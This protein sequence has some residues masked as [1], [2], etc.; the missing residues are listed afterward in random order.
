MSDMQEYVVTAKT[1]DDATS[2]L[3]DMETIGGSLYIPDRQVEVTQR[4]EISRNTHFL[5]TAEEAE[6]LRNDTRVLA[7]ELLPSAQGIVAEPH[8]TQTGNFE[9][10][11]TIDTNDKNW[12]LYRIIAGAPLAN[13]GTNAIAFTQTTQTITTTSSGKN[14]DVVIVDAHINPLHPEF[15]VNSDGTG[16][17]RVNQYNWFQHSAYLALSTTGS[18]SYS[19]ISSNHGTHV[20]GTVAGN[21]QGWARDA[22]IYNMEF[23]YAGGNGPAGDWSLY[24]FDYLRAFHLNKPINPA[25]GKRNPTV[26]NHSWGY[27][28]GSGITVSAVTSVTYRGVTTAV[29]GTDADK[30]VTLEANGVPVPFDSYLYRP[31]YRYPALDAD[32]Q[33]AIAEGIIVVS[34]AGNSYWNCATPDLQD[35]FNTVT[36]TGFGSWGHMRGSSPGAADNVI[37]VGSV[38]TTTQEY[39]SVF[40]NYGKRVD[41]WAPGSNIVS[42]V[43]NTTAAAEFGITLVNDP[44]NASYKLGS[45]SGT[46]MSGPQ[47]AG[48]LACVA[49]QQPRLKQAEALQHL[50]SNSNTT[51]GNSTATHGMPGAQATLTATNSRGVSMNQ[52]WYFH[53]YQPDVGIRQVQAGWLV[54]GPG[55]VNVEIA[56]VNHSNVQSTILI[57]SVNF[58]TGQSQ[59]FQ[60]EGE[61]TFTGI[62]PQSW[63]DYTSLGPNSNN[64]Y[65]FYKLVRPVSGATTPAVRFKD[66][67]ATGLTY[68]RTRIRKYG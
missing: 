52:F 67:P 14:V 2:L 24:I 49:E 35:W 60:G 28:L 27:S 16:G 22:N 21:T 8:W 57:N 33:D 50:I 54:T 65:M 53:D 42:G 5:I 44:R 55:L 9:K 26:T 10:Y 62:V 68:P 29:T 40:S 7:V 19:S 3:D 46:S 31:P 47:V 59:Q 11:A 30:K 66:R 36:A 43:Y 1:M 25:T 51:V 56:Q 37:C 13:W 63:G 58:D 41:I 23:I 39:K 32:I 6:Q 12:G 15:A 64:R 48:Y 38:G 34:S 17:S 61:Y 4:R 20:A 45:I 18:Y